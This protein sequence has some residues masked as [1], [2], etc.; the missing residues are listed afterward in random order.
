MSKFLLAKRHFHS[1]PEDDCVNQYVEGVS[2]G[3]VQCHPSE[4]VTEKKNNVLWFVVMSDAL[5]TTKN[6]YKNHSL[7]CYEV[8]KITVNCFPNSRNAQSTSDFRVFTRTQQGFE[9]SAPENQQQR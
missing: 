8:A 3:Q 9:T 5:F 2:T 6:L 1:R 7:K 4:P